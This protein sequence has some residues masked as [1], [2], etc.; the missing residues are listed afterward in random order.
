MAPG[1]TGTGPV[2]LA[3]VWAGPG[4]A[5]T[6]GVLAGD[7]GLVGDVAG[8]VVA[9]T[10]AVEAAGALAGTST[11]DGADETLA[12]ASAPNDPPDDRTP[13]SKATMTAEQRC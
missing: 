12:A 5:A 10:D 3:G 13:A 2:G 8:A 6:A 11:D 9:G 7:V 4:S 1:G